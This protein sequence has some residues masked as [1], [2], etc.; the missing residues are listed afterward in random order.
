MRSAVDGIPLRHCLAEPVILNLIQGNDVPTLTETA[1]PIRG[2][3]L[4]RETG[5]Q[6]QIV[7]PSYRSYLETPAVQYI[8]APKNHSIYVYKG[9]DIDIDKPNDT[10]ALMPYAHEGLK[11][12]K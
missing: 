2:V 10:E 7:I 5:D 6:T 12:L 4:I 8:D 11:A 3:E 1:I 9:L